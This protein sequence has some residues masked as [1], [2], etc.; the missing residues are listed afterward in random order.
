MVAWM[1]WVLRE[2]RWAGEGLSKV[3]Y[4]YMTQC[5]KGLTVAA[6]LFSHWDC[7]TLPLLFLQ[8]NFLSKAL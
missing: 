6:L 8:V 7:P 1:V 5:A 2:Q 3:S 4:V